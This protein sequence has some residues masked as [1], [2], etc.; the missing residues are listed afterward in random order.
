[1][2][3]TKLKLMKG[4]LTTCTSGYWLQL[5]SISGL[6]L[7][8]NK[9]LNLESTYMNFLTIHLFVLI[10]PLK[11]VESCV[12]IFIF[13]LINSGM[14]NRIA[15]VV[16]DDASAAERQHTATNLDNPR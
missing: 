10:S 13:I 7:V 3:N 8:L 5:G 15:L 9:R 2:I 11:V 14:I 4:L 16:D 1:M 6:K 12:N